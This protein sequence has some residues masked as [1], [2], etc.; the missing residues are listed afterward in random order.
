MST[1]PN[2]WPESPVELSRFQEDLSRHAPPSW[3]PDW[4]TCVIGG[5][6]VCFNRWGSGKGR[7][8]D[9]GWAGAA[10]YVEKRI[11]GST[12]IQGEAEAPYEPGF[13]ALRE[14]SLLERAV[15]SLPQLPDILLVNATGYDHPRGAGL[16]THLGYVLDIPSIGVTHRPL[17]A[18][19]DW[20]DLAKGSVSPVYIDGNVVGSWVATRKNARPLVVHPGWR[21]DIAVGQKVVLAATLQHRS[22]EPLREARRVARTA[23][24][25]AMEISTSE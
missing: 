20:P 2:A 22:P 13:L 5:C 3:E 1:V 10:L 9:P 25:R 24:S 16:A 21:T 15:R 17:I 23:R 12:V 6:Y 14:G 18:Q 7:K 8:G 4:D 11:I 19:G